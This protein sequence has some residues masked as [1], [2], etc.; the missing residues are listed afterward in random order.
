MMR[1]IAAIFFCL[2]SEMKLK[3][4]CLKPKKYSIPK[5]VFY[6]SYEMKLKRI[7]LIIQKGYFLELT[8]IEKNG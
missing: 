6:F 7:F 1:A 8:L 2:F 4:Y 3:N 5:I